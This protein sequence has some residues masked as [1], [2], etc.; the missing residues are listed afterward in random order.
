MRALLLSLV[1]ALCL[2]ACVAGPTP[3][4]GQESAGPGAVNDE[5]DDPTVPGDGLAD[6][7]MEPTPD[8]DD[9]GGGD[10]DAGPVPADTDAG[11]DTDA[12]PDTA[13]DTVTDT[14]TSTDTATDTTRATD[15]IGA[16]C[17]DGASPGSG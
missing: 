11:L 2:P 16:P 14:A 3:H 4:P 15:Q 12:D 6:A 17:E 5:G 10:N 1:I 9:Q 7:A 8:L 13:T